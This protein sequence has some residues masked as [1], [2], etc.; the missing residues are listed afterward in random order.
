MSREAFSQT[1]RTAYEM[2]ELM[3]TSVVEARACTLSF[4]AMLFKLDPD[5]TPTLSTEDASLYV[6]AVE[7]VLLS[8]LGSPTLNGLQ[9]CLMLVLYY[10]VSGSLQSATM[11]HSLA[12]RCVVALGGHHRQCEVD[13][14]NESRHCRR[15]F[16]LCYFIDK[17]ITL[18]TGQSPIFSD[19]EVD[20][21]L[22]H[23]Y[24]FYSLPLD[25]SEVS[26]QQ[27]LYFSDLGLTRIK[28][29]ICTSLWSKA[30]AAKT[31]AQLIVDITSMDAELE[32]W[33]LSVPELFRPH[34]SMVSE[35]I[36]GPMH[37]SAKMLV[38]CSHLEYFFLVAAVH[39]ASGQ[40]RKW[41]T[42]GPIELGALKSS[43][44]VTIEA[45][46]STLQLLKAGLWDLQKEL[47]WLFSFYPMWS[48]MTLFCYILY[49]PIS[50]N[51]QADLDLLKLVPRLMRSLPAS[52]LDASQETHLKSLNAFLDELPRLGHLAV[53]KAKKSRIET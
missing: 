18:R 30:A 48:A 25:G 45:S 10:Q 15:L 20:L 4:V 8:T 42:G 14:T 1:L 11:F 5:Y 33:R 29:K 49:D 24:N 9:A 51:V 40:R 3:S 32:G 52:G 35:V 23:N 17:D 31:N 28:S 26:S 34:L 47:F 21:G 13:S 16:W 53:A 46:R 36:K 41:R 37:H 12:C 38:I 6:T 2:G 22:P 39:R 7:R 43:M 19:A 27:P 50:P 44:Q